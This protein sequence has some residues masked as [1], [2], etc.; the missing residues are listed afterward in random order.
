M[1]RKTK[2]LEVSGTPVAPNTIWRNWKLFIG[3]AVGWDTNKLVKTRPKLAKLLSY[4]SFCTLRFANI[5]VSPLKSRLS[6][7]ALK[8]NLGLYS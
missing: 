3:V 1:S 5:G 7:V 8:N 2:L 4:F 6:P